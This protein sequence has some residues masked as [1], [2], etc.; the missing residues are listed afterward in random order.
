MAVPTTLQDMMP[1]IR[2]LMR[3]YD[4]QH[5]Y[6]FGSAAKGSL[7]RPGILISLSGSSPAWIMKRMAITIS[8]FC[9]LYR[10]CSN[11]MLTLLLKKRYKIPI[12]RRVSRSI[13][14]RYY[15]IRGKEVAHR[16]QECYLFHR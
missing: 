1:G 12:S 14:F 2:E 7:K 6:I 15:D 10:N 11:G 13:N 9:T 3:R 4:V 16:H 5:A 8:D